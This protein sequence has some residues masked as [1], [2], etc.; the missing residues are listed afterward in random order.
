MKLE[1]DD[2]PSGI[3]NEPKD[4]ENGDFFDKTDTLCLKPSGNPAKLQEIDEDPSPK[5]LEKAFV[6]EEEDSARNDVITSTEVPEEALAKETKEVETS[7]TNRNPVQNHQHHQ[8]MRMS[9]QTVS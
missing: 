5:V 7:H 6:E 3:E 9:Y 1:I 4:I 2:K 8:K